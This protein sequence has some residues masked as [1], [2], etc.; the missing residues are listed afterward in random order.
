M[1]ELEERI[2]R[3][4]PVGADEPRAGRDIANVLGLEMRA[5]RDHILRLI[6]R[7]GIP[8]VAKRGASNGYYIPA[9]DTERLA[10][11]RELKAQYDTEGRRLDVLI[12]ADLESYKELLKGADKNV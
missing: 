4:I 6:V 12:K 1:T 5:L 10:G 2:L 8:I 9:N 3:L 7:Y 11:I